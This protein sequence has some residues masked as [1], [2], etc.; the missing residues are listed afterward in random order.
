MK[1]FVFQKKF[2]YLAGPITGCTKKEANNWREDFNNKLNSNI[3][4][5]SPL[6]CEPIE[7]EYYTS[8]NDI[9]FGTAKAINGKNYYDTLNC[10]LVLAYLPKKLNNKRPSYGTVIEI[11]W[12]IGMRKPIIVVTDDKYFS[13]HPLIKSNVAWVLDNFDDALIVIN[14]LFNDY[15]ENK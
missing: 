4:G 2:V 14:G 1:N 3:I 6:R 15:V 8:S 13:E 5:V 11:G 7:G 12:A 9:K 10:D